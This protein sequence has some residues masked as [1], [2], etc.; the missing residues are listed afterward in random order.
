MKIDEIK[1]DNGIIE[2]IDR[3]EEDYIVIKLLREEKGIIGFALVDN[4]AKVNN[5]YVEVELEHRSNGYGKLLFNEALKEYSKKFNKKELEFK[6]MNKNLIN[7]IISKS[8]GI[9]IDNDDGI[10]TYIVP[11]N[12]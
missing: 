3:L 6:I 5:I 11:L 4:N 2:I 7:I 9:Q 8:G 10:Y 1:L 12:K